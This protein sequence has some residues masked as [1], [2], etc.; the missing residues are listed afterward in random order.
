M[1]RTF[2]L[3]LVASA[4][5]NAALALNLQPG[6][7][8]VEKDGPPV[9]R[10]FFR[11]ESKQVLFHID[12]KMSVSGSTNQAVFTFEDIRNAK[13]RLTTSGVPPQ[14]PFDE[15]NLE[16]YRTAMRGF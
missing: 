12:S 14:T 10:Y 9:R 6:E 5:I 4:S 15:K 3:L 7:I 2:T 1:K 16:L 11:D 13:M 8:T